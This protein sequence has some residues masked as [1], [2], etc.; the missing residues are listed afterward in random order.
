MW[1][2]IVNIIEGAR[3]FNCSQ[4]IRRNEVP[5]RGS[6]LVA[7]EALWPSLQPFVKRGYGMPSCVLG[8]IMEVRQLRGEC[9]RSGVDGGGHVA[10]TG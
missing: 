3:S 1:A 8:C 10:K 5:R 4:V 9:I 2:I 7:H 6:K